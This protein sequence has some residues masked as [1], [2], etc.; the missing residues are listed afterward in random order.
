MIEEKYLKEHVMT[1]LDGRK[2]EKCGVD[3]VIN[4]MNITENW[5]D[6][7]TKEYIAF[8][9]HDTDSKLDE[10]FKQ[11][12]IS[13]TIRGGG[14]KKER[15]NKLFN[16][17]AEAIKYKRVPFFK[18][19]FEHLLDHCNG[20]PIGKIPWPWSD[21]LQKILRI[22]LPV[23]IDMQALEATKDKKGYLADLY[24]DLESLYESGK[25]KDKHFQQKL[26]DLWYFLKPVKYKEKASPDAK[27]FDPIPEDK[28]ENLRLLA[29][30][31][32]RKPEESPIYKFFE[33]LDKNNLSPKSFINFKIDE[34]FTFHEWY[35]KLA[36]ELRKLL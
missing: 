28:T 26:Y 24:R 3:K 4:E 13:Y 22:F 11:N 6:N 2:F 29:G 31:N 14:E 30:L 23:D 5:G 32:C 9:V 25:N 16:P 1:V 36:D 20:K 18:K 7:T 8:A 27:I 34:N 35:I 10:V 21:T 33:S 15:W 17:I 12:P 19:R